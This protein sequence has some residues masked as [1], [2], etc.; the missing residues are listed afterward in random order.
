MI[1]Q[2]AKLITQIKNR[3]KKVVFIVG[4]TGV[5][6]TQAGLSLS[7]LLPCEFISADSMQIYQG[8]D[9]ITDKLPPD[10]R[11]KYPHH[12]VDIIPV[13]K[14][15]NVADF[16]RSAKAA[17]EE[18]IKKKKTPVVIGGTGLYVNS[19]IHG[20][21]EAD[22]ND[23]ELRLRLEAQAQASGTAALY[24]KLKACDPDAAAKINVSDKRRIIRA[25]E[26]CEVAK[27]PISDL[28]RERHGLAD[29]YDILLF[30][31]RRKR[32]DLYRRIEQRVDF[33]ANAGL[34]DEVRL[35]LGGKLSRTAYMCIGVREIEGFLKGEYDLNEAL[36]LIKIN[37]RHFAKRQMTW[38]N[39]S[40]DINWIDVAPDEDMG[41]TAKKIF[42]II[43]GE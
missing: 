16:V 28:Q 32:D 25:L 36:R 41:L 31:L 3:F 38:F 10:L 17:V 34:L 18:I 12:L 5:G 35:L 7:A 14:D 21:F 2:I 6:K 15:H 30:G 27:R 33:M 29:E 23:P 24:E 43:A 39:K 9:I 13:T 8:M 1:T 4:P 26:V 42:K 37:S 22:S 20:I 19:L 11:K 40:K